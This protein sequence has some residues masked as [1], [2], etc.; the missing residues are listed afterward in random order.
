[1]NFIKKPYSNP[2]KPN[3][4]HTQ[5]RLTR[6]AMISTGI[7]PPER[8][9]HNH[10]VRA[11]RE[12]DVRARPLPTTVDARR[13]GDTARD[14]NLRRTARAGVPIA[15]H[16]EKAEAVTAALTRLVHASQHRLRVGPAFRQSRA[17][18]VGMEDYRMASVLA[19]A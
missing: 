18:S 2:L 15:D 16:A 11:N 3:V 12:E 9:I 13:L 8:S 1:V 4:C 19:T 5:A 17:S 7:E 14:A 6:R 10:S